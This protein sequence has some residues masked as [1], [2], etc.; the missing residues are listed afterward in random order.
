[1]KEHYALEIFT[2]ADIQ[3]EVINTK[4]FLFLLLPEQSTSLVK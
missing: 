1:M 4:H 2:S 3:I